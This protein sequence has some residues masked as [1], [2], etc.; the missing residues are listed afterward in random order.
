MRRKVKTYLAD[1][2]MPVIDV[3]GELDALSHHCEPNALV[4][5][6]ATFGY[7]NNSVPA[8]RRRQPSPSSISSHSSQSLEQQKQKL[9]QQPKFGWS[10]NCERQLKE[11]YLGVDSPQ[12]VQK[13]LSLVH[14]SKIR[15]QASP[16]AA[17]APRRP[18]S[19]GGAMFAANPSPQ[20]GGGATPKIAVMRRAPSFNATTFAKQNSAE[21]PPPSS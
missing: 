3:E 17:N 5:S 4:N 14:N 13:M 7:N 1:G 10:E 20:P 18:A 2:G 11:S 6:F 12:A 16:T 9:H 8:A 21:L 19:S 15:S